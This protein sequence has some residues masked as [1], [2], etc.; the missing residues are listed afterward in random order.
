MTLEISIKLSEKNVTSQM[1]SPKTELHHLSRKY[2]V[3]KIMGQRI[4]NLSYQG[5]VR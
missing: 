2:L 3:G 1:L 4:L 5:Y